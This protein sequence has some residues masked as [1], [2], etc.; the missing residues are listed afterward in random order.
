MFP[1]CPSSR[2]VCV[3][4]LFPQSLIMVYAHLVNLQ[5]EAVLSFLTSVPGPT[6]QSALHFLLT[7]W[8]GRQHLFYGSYDVKVR[9]AQLLGHGAGSRNQRWRRCSLGAGC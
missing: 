7:E 5:L 3:C 8:C 1:P 2:D 4:P 9:C 6:G